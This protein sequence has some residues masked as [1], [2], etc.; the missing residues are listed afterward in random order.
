MNLFD[1][2][3]TEATLLH[4]FNLA[5]SE[6]DS[7]RSLKKCLK[8]TVFIFHSI[9]SF[10]LLFRKMHIDQHISNNKKPYVNIP[11]LAQLLI[12]ICCPKVGI[13]KVFIK[14]NYIK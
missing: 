11:E 13:I 2:Q 12:C 6:Q 8:L 10:F 14:Y 7:N 9:Y 1:P 4:T 5:P 3:A